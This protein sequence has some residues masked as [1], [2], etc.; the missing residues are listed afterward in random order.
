MWIQFC[1]QESYKWLDMLPKLL[2]KYNNRVHRSIGMKP[3]QVSVNNVDLIYD[4]LMNKKQTTS[5]PPK[6][7]IGDIDMIFKF[8]NIFLK[9][10]SHPVQGNY[11]Q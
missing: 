4:S 8:K 2:W 7:K 11:L 10:T 3:N 1:I 9:D 5:Q 6:F